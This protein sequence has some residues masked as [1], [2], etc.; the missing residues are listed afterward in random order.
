ML[1]L[2]IDYDKIIGIFMSAKQKG[3]AFEREISKKLSLW[4][5]NN[6]RDD[7]FYRTDASGARYTQ[8]MKKNKNTVN[9]IG[10]IS[11]KDLMGADLIKK[12]IIEVKRGYTTENLLNVLDEKNKNIIIEWLVKLQLEMKSSMKKEFLIFWKRDRHDI[13]CICNKLTFE[14]I[15]TSL[16]NYIILNYNNENFYII[17]SKILF[18]SDYNQFIS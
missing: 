17:N 16:N 18:S 10:D 5:S 14:R 12:F 7:I 15:K 4:V 2:G 13:I 8:R 11:F 3:N 6:T 1:R 9:S